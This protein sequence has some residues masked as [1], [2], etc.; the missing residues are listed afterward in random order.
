MTS[1]SLW[2]SPP[3]ATQHDLEDALQAVLEGKPLRAETV[4]CYIA[5]R[6]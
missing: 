6:K 1:T 4:G 2:A 5:R 3:G